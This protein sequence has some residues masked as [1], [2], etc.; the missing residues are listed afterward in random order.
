MQKYSTL[1]LALR[2]RGGSGG[3]TISSETD[4]ASRRTAPGNLDKM[5]AIDKGITL[6]EEGQER[7][8]AVTKCTWLRRK[9]LA[10]ADRCVV[11]LWPACRPLAKVLGV[12]VCQF[13]SDGPRQTLPHTKNAAV[14]RS[15]NCRSFEALTHVSSLLACRSS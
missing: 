2:L 15:F 7:M 6:V 11:I 13:R 8:E 14:V 3:T 12:S 5:D 9:A 1:H 10:C 4:E